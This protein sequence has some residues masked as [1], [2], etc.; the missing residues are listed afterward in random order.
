MS[1]QPGT[2]TVAIPT[3]NRRHLLERAV[4]SVLAES[5]VPILVSV[6]DNASTDDTAA[7]MLALA[8]RDPRLEFHSNA[9]NIGG[10]NNI[11]KGLAAVRTPY[12]VPLA[13]DDYLLPDFLHDAHRI[14]E[15]DPEL[16]A[17]LFGT[18]ARTEQGMVVETYPAYLRQCPGGRI[19]PQEHLRQWLRHGHCAWSSI[20]WRSTVLA[21]IGAPYMHI[22]LPS[23]VDFQAQA[24]ARFP[25][26]LVDRPGAV[27]SMHAAQASIGL[28]TTHLEGW[29][30]LFS[31]LDRSVDGLAEFGRDEYMALRRIAWQRF[32]GVWNR[33]VTATLPP[34][35][36]ARLA[37]SAGFD[38]GDWALAYTLAE[39]AT[40]GN[41]TAAD[42]KIGDAT[43]GNATPGN[44]TPGNATI[45]DATDRAGEA[46]RTHWLPSADGSG[47][48][49]SVSGSRHDLMLAIIRW[50]RRS[51]ERES[52]LA[53]RL[54]AAGETA[55]RLEGDAQGWRT[56][57]ETLA[58]EAE[59]WRQRC[60]AAEGRLAA[61]ER[62]RPLGWLRRLRA[63]SGPSEHTQRRNAP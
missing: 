37:V 6:L 46:E 43:P 42:A 56:R 2:I 3:F 49:D 59:T 4:H 16:G 54:A 10:L 60:E 29:A 5:R 1:T 28:D 15:A 20:L 58:R 62:Q 39:A 35:R 50:F 13:D 38:L 61:H 22:G 53:A 19:E 12:F 48:A 32:R 45:G 44:A 52:G 11:A 21:H 36:Q 33:P 51:A 57:A 47:D 30:A 34:G 18:H 7:C 24:F 63:S 23:D 40:P 9:T 25:A 14:M 8:A 41:A 26:F 31:R 55:T 27:Y 17:T